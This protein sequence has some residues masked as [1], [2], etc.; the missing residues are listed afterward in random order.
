MEDKTLLGAHLLDKIADRLHAPH[1]ADATL[2]GT[3]AEAAAAGEAA[4]QRE[5]APTP[6]PAAG[7][8]AEMGLRGRILHVVA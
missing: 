7:A 6:L 2:H 1:M 8:P 4:V 5:T 3:R